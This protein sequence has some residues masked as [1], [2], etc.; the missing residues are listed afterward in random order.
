M[1][2]EKPLVSIGQDIFYFQLAVSNPQ[3][4]KVD[5]LKQIKTHRRWSFYVPRKVAR[6]FN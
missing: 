2:A 4:V 6:D 1:N 5:F 3:K